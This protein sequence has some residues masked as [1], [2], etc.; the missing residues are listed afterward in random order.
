MRN[1]RRS[2]SP[3]FLCA[4]KKLIPSSQLPA[5]LYLDEDFEVENS[6][7]KTPSYRDLHIVR[8]GNLLIHYQSGG[9][10]SF[11]VSAWALDRKN[12]T[13]TP[14][15]FCIN[16]RRA[17]RKGMSELDDFTPFELGG[18]VT[19]MNPKGEADDSEIEAGEELKA[20][21]HG[22]ALSQKTVDD[23]PDVDDS[24]QTVLSCFFTRDE[25]GRLQLPARSRSPQAEKQANFY[26]NPDLKPRNKQELSEKLATI[27]WQDLGIEV[28][29]IKR[30]LGEYKEETGRAVSQ[31]DF[32]ELEA[33]MIDKSRYPFKMIL[34][35]MNG[36]FE[37]ALGVERK[38]FSYDKESQG[39]QGSQGSEESSQ[40][41]QPSKSRP[42]S[43]VLYTAFFGRAGACHTHRKQNERS[44]PGN[45]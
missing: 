32:K 42:W 21:I 7:G 3:H 6:T 44:G 28:G 31:A 24:I 39:S 27:Y 13:M 30:V 23:L 12:K 35:D 17:G 43:E 26:L 10:G 16:L 1:F 40:A 38:Y 34:A 45:S 22:L 33:I 25:K 5:A 18:C 15:F 4:P 36:A 11:Q 37:K 20:F 29:Q 41:Q 8:M 14:F 19:I 9:K 2:E